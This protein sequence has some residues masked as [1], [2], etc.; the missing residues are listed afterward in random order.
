MTSG[1]AKPAGDVVRPVPSLKRHGATARDPAPEAAQRTRAPDATPSVTPPLSSSIPALALG[2]RAA[3]AR[4]SSNYPL[5]RQATQSAGR[6]LDDALEARFA[7]HLQTDLSD[8][9]I[10]TGEQASRSAEGIEAQA[11]TVGQDIVF[12][13]GQYRPDSADGQHLLAHELAHVAQPDGPRT[14]AVSQPTD[15]SEREADHVADA[16]MQGQTARPRIAATAAAQ[17]EP[18]KEASEPAHE[19][20]LNQMLDHA[21]LFLAASIGSATL[22]GFDTGKSD[23]KPA[24]IAELKKTAYSITSLLHHYPQSTVTVI[25]HTDTV[26]TEA[27]NLELG[28]ARAMAAADALEKLGVPAAIVTTSSAGEA[29]PQAVKTRD[30]APNAQNRRVDIR[31]EPQAAQSVSVVPKLEPKGDEKTSGLAQTPPPDINYHGSLDPSYR[32]P[33]YRPDELPLDFWKPIPTA[34]KGVGPKSVI[35]FIGERVIDPVVD[36]V[37]HGLSKQ[38]RDKIKEAARDSVKTGAAKLARLAAEGAGVNDQ[39]ALDAIENATK[40]AIQ[41]KGRAQP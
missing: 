13:V 11:Y 16:L 36:R 15:A 17:R 12:G 40:A 39:Q 10:H 41:E 22:S 18:Q 32:G 37:A 14:R 34:P 21:S 8:V 24:H 4:G 25:G 35:D 31:F 1:P 7:A 27:H 29:A 19:P 20:V 26:G 2:E 23:L 5:I 38:A 28:A 3:G 9:R 33:P 30:E 6:P